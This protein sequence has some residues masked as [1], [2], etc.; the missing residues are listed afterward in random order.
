MSILYPYFWLSRYAEP[1]SPKRR[2][3]ILLSETNSV[4]HNIYKAVKSLLAPTKPKRAQKMRK[5]IRHAEC[6]FT[7]G[8][9][10]PINASSKHGCYLEILA[11][12]KSQMDAM[13]S[14]HSKVL[15]VRMDLRQR[16]YTADNK[17]MADFMRKLKKRLAR[18]YD[19]NRIAYLWVREVERSKHQHYHLTLMLDGNKVRH[20]SNVINDVEFIADGWDWPKPFTPK[21]CYYL[22]NRSDS[23]TYANAFKRGSYLAKTRGKGYKAATANNYGR[24]NIRSNY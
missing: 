23:E 8:I 14:H 3:G 16:D 13:L 19:T 5:V 6:K 22:I 7:D 21:N 4:F 2:H 12:L 15:F 10:L 11:A 1:S 20:S 17:P 24:S 18:R 9:T